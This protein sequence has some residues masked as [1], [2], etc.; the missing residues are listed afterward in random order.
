[1][2]VRMQQIVWALDILRWEAF[3]LSVPMEQQTLLRAQLL[4]GSV[5]M[6]PQIHLYVLCAPME[7]QIHLR[8]QLLAGSVL[9]EQ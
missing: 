1:M 3:S 2:F 4:E 5:L 6:E 8:V 7:Q 9:M